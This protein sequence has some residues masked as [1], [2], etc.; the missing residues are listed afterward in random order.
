M[1]LV[2]VT[3]ACPHAPQDGYTLRVKRMLEALV[4]VAGG[5]LERVVLVTP[6]E[7]AE[8]EPARAWA[9]ATGIELDPYPAT[10]LSPWH[11]EARTALRA[12]V[13][14]RLETLRP[15]RERTVVFGLGI[16]G[17][18]EL[19]HLAPEWRVVGDVMD[20]VSPRLQE[21]L[22][23]AAASFSPRGV[24]R[25]LHTRREYLR[26]LRGLS[27]CAAVL[28]CAPDD[29]QRLCALEANRTVE[30]VW[31]GVDVPAARADVA[32]PVRRAIFHGVLDY[33]PNEQ[34]ALTICRT[35]APAL[36]AAAPDLRLLLVGRRPTP[37][38][39]AAAAE[40]ANVDVLQDVPS[41]TAHLLDAGIGLYPLRIRTGI[42]NK[43][44]EAWAAGLPVITTTEIAQSL[45]SITASAQE[46]LVVADEPGLV[47]ALTRLLAS[48]ADRVR[49][50]NAGRA[51]VEADFSWPSSARRL[52]HVLQA[53]AGR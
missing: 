13:A 16:P 31:N 29:A 23:R 27:R 36:R 38:V 14:R 37:A 44:L 41:V 10:G 53:A 39:L 51:V 26:E 12:A 19:A 15:V 49:L 18:F 5:A 32:A 24:V 22:R 33:P 52:L 4:G 6:A 34:A 7:P 45:V 46:A 8:L 47:D 28:A 1:H 21:D 50:G 11:R 42:Q 35:A 30:A 40:Q 3:F 9:R 17:L 2:A 43:I 25:A 20:E 48:A